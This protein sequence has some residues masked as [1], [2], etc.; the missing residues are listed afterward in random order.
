[1]EIKSLRLDFQTLII[2][3]PQNNSRAYHRRKK[4][5]KKKK[6]LEEPRQR[7]REGRKKKKKTRR[8]QAACATWVACCLGHATQAARPGHRY[9]RRV[10]AFCLVAQKI[11]RFGFL[12]FFF[13]CVCWLSSFSLRSDGVLDFLSFFFFCVFWLE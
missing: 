10:L 13:F 3:K 5:K 1:M 4:K 11:I 8:T 6:K 9:R 7:I 2:T 12:K